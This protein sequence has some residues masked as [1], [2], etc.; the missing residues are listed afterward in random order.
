MT[1]LSLRCCFS[2][3][4][5]SA[6]LVLSET[7]I[8]KLP[9]DNAFEDARKIW[10]GI[11]DKKPGLMVKCREAADVISCVNLARERDLL[12]AVRGGGHNVA[13]NAVCNGGLV[14]DLSEMRSVRADVQNNVV[15]IAGGATLGD[16]DR[17]TSVHGLATPM[18]VVTATGYA[19]LA[20]HGGMGWQMRKH[21]L[22]A[23]NIVGVDIVLADGRLVRADAEANADLFWAVRGGGGNFGVVTSFTSRL[24]PIPKELLFA[25]PIFS[26][27]NA[28]AVLRF[29]RDYMAEAPDELMVLG[30]LWTAPDIPDIAPQHRGTP[31]L[32]LLGCYIGPP[33]EAEAV[34]K[35][36]RTC[37][38]AIAD[39]TSR[40][41]W[42]D[43][44]KF[45]DEDYPNGRRYYWKS[46][47]IKELT[48]PVIEALVR[49][50]ASRPSLLT[51]IDI[52][53]MGG[54]FGRV[55]PAAAAFGSRDIGFTI[56]YESNW[57]DADKDQSNIQWT[58][59]S[60][61][62][63]QNLTQ[64]RTYLNFAGLAEE[65][66]NMVRGSFGEN[67]SRLQ[68]VKAKYDPYNL[69]RTN[70][71]ISPRGKGADESGL[72]TVEM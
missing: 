40:K 33:E 55:D 3:F 16:V 1:K 54:A 49:Q 48:D 72:H 47:L 56:N 42:V 35:P 2:F 63:V 34:L 30:A 39:L 17:E 11:I 69:F 28:A 71:N 23:D 26:L 37:R 25:V 36:L 8:D 51:S 32:F 53:P 62:E 4:P 68:A 19:G 58:R 57:D 46:T 18:G 64:A 60:L 6:I 14:V 9:G 45:F 65:M 67:Y 38:P 7:V 70:F 50:A 5:P 24:H 10:N 22:A 44:Q 27:D 59:A 20:L 41:S 29:L 52:W 61:T 15:H 66:E 13:G 21:G 43:V 31:V 12:L